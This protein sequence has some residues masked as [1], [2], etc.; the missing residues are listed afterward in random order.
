MARSE[1]KEENCAILKFKM[2]FL[3]AGVKFNLR[4]STFDVHLK[5]L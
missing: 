1:I 2:N 4:K 3:R 5:R